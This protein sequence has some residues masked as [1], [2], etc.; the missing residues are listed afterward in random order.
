ME[1][2]KLALVAEDIDYAMALSESLMSI[3]A[4]FSVELFDPDDHIDFTACGADLIIFDHP[5]TGRPDD[6]IELVA[7]ESQ[8]DRNHFRFFKYGSSKILANEIL[9]VYGAV[10]GRN[11]IIPEKTGVKMYAFVSARGGVGCTSVAVAYAQESVRFRGRKVL[12]LSLE[13]IESTEQYMYAEEGKGITEFLYYLF[14]G[15]EHICSCIEDFVCSDEYGTEAFRPGKG[16]N[17]LRNLTAEEFDKFLD[18]LIMCGRYMII[19][20]DIGNSLNQL[21]MRAVDRSNTICCISADRAG[22]RE[23]PGELWLLEGSNDLV[24]EENEE[25]EETAAADCRQESYERY[26]K[27]RIGE[28]VLEK[29]VTVK[30][31][32]GAGEEACGKGTVSIEN[33]PASFTAHRGRT[34][35]SIDKSFGLGIKELADEMEPI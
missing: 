24:S 28:D 2:I 32:C 1:K 35:I 3:Q 7:K 29:S 22:R 21:S 27:Y 20:V 25:Y 34:R 10:R 8:A 14:S 23:D 5:G 12:Y 26:L 17:P 16:L 33:D 31:L 4:R 11:V 15:R 9:F 13:D 18:F 19:A 6:H 30:N